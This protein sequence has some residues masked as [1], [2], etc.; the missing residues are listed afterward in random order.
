MGDDIMKKAVIILIS[1]LFLLLCSCGQVP[2]RIALS[3]ALRKPYEA[4]VAV[5]DN[6]SVYKATVCSDEN[7]IVFTFTEPELL[8]GISYG[9]DNEK[10]CIVY[11]DLSIPVDLNGARDKLSSGVLV[12]KKLLIADGEYTVR[13]ANDQ[14]VMTDGKA[15]YR[16]ES[17]NF[18]PV[19]IKNE[20][21]TITITD[22]KVKNDQTP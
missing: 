4:T 17:E 8:R 10:S 11:N 19:F 20:N 18:T 15:E 5:N 6:E 22:F 3:E 14:Y 1:S 7:G 21:I 16:F 13:R 12:W 9:F 2:D